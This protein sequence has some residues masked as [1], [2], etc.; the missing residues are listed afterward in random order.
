MDNALD[1]INN[2]GA[3]VKG[4]SQFIKEVLREKVVDMGLPSN[5][6]WAV[7]DIDITQKDGFCKTPFTYDKSFFS[8]GNIVGHTPKNNSF[9]DVYDWGSVNPAEPWYDGQPYG[10]TKGATLMGNIPVGE[11]FDAAR[12]TLG[13]NW[14]MP[15][16][17]EFAELLAGSI[18]INADGTEVDISKG[19]KRVI[20]NNI[21]GI[22]LQSKTNGNRLFFSASG[23]GVGNSWNNRGVNGYYWSSMFDSSRN[24]INLSFYSGNV[25]PQ[26]INNRCDGFAIRAVHE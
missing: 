1:I 21:V 2:S 5:L 10:N 19:D 3:F 18:Y 25:N 8:W 9:I 24:A 4:R 6:K 20:V 16:T 17:D 11:E 14:R 26:R 15:T 22:Y 7:C 13:Q 23:L 12:A